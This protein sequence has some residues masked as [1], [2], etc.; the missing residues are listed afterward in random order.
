MALQWTAGPLCPEH[1]RLPLE[2][3]VNA[4]PR[5]YLEPPEDGELFTTIETYY[6]RLTGFSLSQGFDVVKTHSDLSGN[7]P[8]AMF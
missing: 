7:N 2:R 1:I 3:A 8:S 4:L 5:S 6:E